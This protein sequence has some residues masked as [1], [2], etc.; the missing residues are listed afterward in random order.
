MQIVISSNSEKSIHVHIVRFIDFFAKLKRK[1]SSVRNDT[2]GG[3]I[4]YHHHCCIIINLFN[5]TL[6]P[7]H[8]QFNGFVFGLIS[9]LNSR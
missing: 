9:T 4:I 7:M 8:H 2:L 3:L 6:K 5:T 1:F